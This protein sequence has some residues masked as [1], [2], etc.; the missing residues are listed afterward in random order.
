[1]WVVMP[2]GGWDCQQTSLRVMVSLSPWSSLILTGRHDEARA[3]RR[4]GSE[5]VA[6]EKA[7]APA[8]HAA[9]ATRSLDLVKG[10]LKRKSL[11]VF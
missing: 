1:M 2:R 4:V 6:E 10:M 9:A 7:S 8:M 5:E 3:V 11:R